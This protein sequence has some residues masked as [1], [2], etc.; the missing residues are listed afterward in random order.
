MTSA[1][2]TSSVTSSASRR[3]GG[4]G[5]SENA[6]LCD[7]LATEHATIYGYG[8]VSAH[9]PPGV[10]D[11]ASAAMSQHREH[12]DH[13][14]TLLAARSVT[15][16]VAAAGYQLPMPVNDE[17]DAARLAVRME[18]DAAVAWRAVIEQ[19]Q[20]T[21]ERAFGVTALTQSAVLA[22]RWNQQLRTWP[23]TAAFPGG[24]E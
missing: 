22:A 21:D 6:A 11:L 14:I 2:P 16:P 20:T 4:N 10:N 9:S 17:R 7:A 23:I 18:N 8:I 5:T 13:V 19:A 3:P 15:P 24:S 12:R 1:E